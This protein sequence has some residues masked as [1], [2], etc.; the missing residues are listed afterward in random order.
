M[1]I[2][3]SV[4][5]ADAA[6]ASVATSLNSGWVKIYTG[7]AP[8]TTDAAATGTLLAGDIRFGA[9]AFGAAATNGSTR[10]IVA[11]TLT[12]DAAADAGGVAG[13]F[14]TFSSAG[15]APIYQGSV[16]ATGS[17]ADLELDST[18]LVQNGQVGISSLSI[19][20]PI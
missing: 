17:G 11:N 10:R 20:Y 9:T 19:S 4:A 16:G 13:Y 14:R 3:L 12:A 6:L 8:S 2:R 15:T 5:A 7:T 1:A 18:T